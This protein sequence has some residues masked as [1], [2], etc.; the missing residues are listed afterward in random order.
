[1]FRKSLIALAATASL[2]AGVAATTTAAEA[3]H[4]HGVVID[5][6]FGGFG[7]GYGGYY[8]GGY[9]DGGYGYDCGYQ[10]RM[11]KIWLS[12]GHAI[13]VQKKVWVCD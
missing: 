4:H 13:F 8:D 11:K 10:L 5:F 7:P 9:Y 2:A 1:M 6:G 12:P 3:H